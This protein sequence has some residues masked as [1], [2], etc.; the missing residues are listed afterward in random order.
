M[1]FKEQRNR[2]PWVVSDL[3]CHLMWCS[4]WFQI[5]YMNNFLLFQRYENQ[6]FMYVHFCWSRMEQFLEKPVDVVLW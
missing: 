1:R 6:M 4:E 3:Q 2:S 5:C